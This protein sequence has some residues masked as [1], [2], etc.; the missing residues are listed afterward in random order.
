[1]GDGLIGIIGT[2]AGALL[3]VFGTIASTRLAGHSQ[4]RNQ[5]DQWRRQSRRDAYSQLIVKATEAISVGDAAHTAVLER[6]PSAGQRVSAF[7]S[8]AGSLLTPVTLVALEGP[9]EASTAAWELIGS[10]S[11]WANCLALTLAPGVDDETRADYWDSAEEH[12]GES[13]DRLDGFTRV[14]R[15]L[16]HD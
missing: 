11:Q 1:M 15:T 5:H 2:I 4:R 13:A 10:L 8:A 9:D 14:C 16:L 3:G 12:N 7:E 6:E